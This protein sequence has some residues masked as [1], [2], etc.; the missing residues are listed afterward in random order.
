MRTIAIDKLPVDQAHALRDWQRGAN[1]ASTCRIVQRL[2]HDLHATGQSLSC[3]CMNRAGRSPDQPPVIFIYHLPGRDTLNTRNGKTGKHTE[4][5]PSCPFARIRTHVLPQ[6]S[7]V[8]SHYDTE[9]T[10]I[11]P[12]GYLVFDGDPLL[13]RGGHPGRSGGRRE[14]LARLLA[15][16]LAEAELESIQDRMIDRLQNALRENAEWWYDLGDTVKGDACMEAIECRKERK[17]ERKRLLDACETR[18]VEKV[19]RLKDILFANPEYLRKDWAIEQ[20]KR[21]RT[22]GRWPD[23]KPLQGYFLFSVAIESAHE[24]K[25]LDDNVAP[26]KLKIEAEIDQPQHLKSTYMALIMFALTQ[27]ERKVILRCAALA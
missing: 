12:D 19:G 16:I 23:K 10:H 24:L 27:D 18:K 2:L 14:F 26:L 22:Q 7:G 9:N 21:L 8:E 13:D 3:N 25:C 11:D 4:H 20:L 15:S 1:D 17:Y 6:E 5:D